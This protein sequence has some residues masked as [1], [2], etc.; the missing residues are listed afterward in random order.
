MPLVQA[1]LCVVHHPV[2]ASIPALSC[3]ND[4]PSQAYP[5][6]APAHSTALLSTTAAA[7]ICT[8]H[9]GCPAATPSYSRPQPFQYDS[10]APRRWL[11]GGAVG[12]SVR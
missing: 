8:R 9:N 7:L 6:S 2:L 1:R 3:T 4:L 5:H 11:D 12:L 10:S